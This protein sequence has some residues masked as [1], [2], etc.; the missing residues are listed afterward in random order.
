MPICEKGYCAGAAVV[1]RFSSVIS[2]SLFIMPWVDPDA[3]IP[4]LIRFW[5][6]SCYL[7]WAM[8]YWL[9]WAEALK[10]LGEMVP[11][12]WTEGVTVPLL[13]WPFAGIA[14]MLGLVVI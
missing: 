1:F 10:L 11:G 5:A 14:L 13:V 4:R 2:C 8:F 6:L 12:V 3:L 9:A 7:V